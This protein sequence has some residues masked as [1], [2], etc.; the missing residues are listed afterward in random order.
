[1]LSWRIDGVGLATL[2]VGDTVY[3]GGTFTKASSPDGSTVT[4]RANLAA[5]SATT[6]ALL[7]S[8]RA[9]SNDAVRTLAYDGRNLYVGGSFTQIGGMARSRLAAL[10]PSTGA[11]RRKWQANASSNVY[12]L[13]V[14]AGRLFV[15]G[16]FLTFKNHPRSRI[17]AVNL[18]DGSLTRFAPDADDTVNTIAVAGDG[19]AIYVGGNYTSI[20]DVRATYLTKLAIDGSVVP[21]PWRTVGGLAL[22]LEVTSDG[23]RLVGALAGEPDTNPG[24]NQGALFDAKTGGKIWIERCDG[25]G[26]AVHIMGDSV[27]TGFHGGCD[28][29]TTIRLTKNN[30]IT[31]ARDTSFIPAFDQFWGVRAISGSSTAL[32]VAGEFTKIS[33]VSVEGFAVFRVGSPSR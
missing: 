18:R 23:K 29:D 24:A 3:V 9:D 10:N 6:G 5:F 30:I 20:N 33:G 14:G 19:S 2:V 25:D 17:A 27:Y 26:Q 12:G 28:G 7:S 31:G 11:V 8:F 16:S 1:L 4:N 13:S 15:A 22:G 21:V 32:A